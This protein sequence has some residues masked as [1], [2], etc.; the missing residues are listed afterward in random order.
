MGSGSFPTQRGVVRAMV[1]GLR[2]S[3]AIVMEQEPT[4]ALTN[5]PSVAPSDNHRVAHGH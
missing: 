1:L 3:S 5:T 4:R 2:H